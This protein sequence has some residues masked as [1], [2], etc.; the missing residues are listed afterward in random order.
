MNENYDIKW[1]VL[2]NYPFR[3]D[4]KDNSGE[5]PMG[6]IAS[7]CYLI[8]KNEV[9]IP[10]ELNN[11]ELIE[12]AF[13]IEGKCTNSRK[14][15][16]IYDSF[17]EA[18]KTTSNLNSVLGARIQ[19]YAYHEFY[20]EHYGSYSEKLGKLLYN[21]KRN[22]EDSYKLEENILKTCG[23]VVEKKLEPVKKN[24]RKK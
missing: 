4:V 5:L 12:P 20:N 21:Y 9:V 11:E 24:T 19:I 15:D 7:P 22:L 3:L 6:Y 10:Y 17:D 14:V 16:Y 1:T 18:K 2:V 23:I 13:D 8:N